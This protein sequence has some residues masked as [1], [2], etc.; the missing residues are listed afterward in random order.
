VRRSIEGLVNGDAIEGSNPRRPK[1]SCLSD[2]MVAGRVL[3]IQKIYL[4]SDTR[5][6][7]SGSFEVLFSRL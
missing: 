3:K 1:I 7:T 6:L 2:Q 5:A 4:K